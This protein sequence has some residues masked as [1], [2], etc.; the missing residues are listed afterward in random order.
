MREI[1]GAG[2]PFAD[3]SLLMGPAFKFMEM[4]V[5]SADMGVLMMIL[6]PGGFLMVGKRML[7]LRAG[8]AIQMG[9]AHSAA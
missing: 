5:M 1:F 9:G 7:D 8:K 2:T 6:P 3:A 4:R